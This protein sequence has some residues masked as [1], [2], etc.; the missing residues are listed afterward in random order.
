MAKK[1]RPRAARRELQRREEKLDRARERLADL[2]P[3]GAP[4]RAIDVESA[5]QVEVEAANRPCPRCGGP[6]RVDEHAAETVGAARLRVAR[7]SCA[8]CGASRQIW[9]RLGGSLPS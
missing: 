7:V 5:S 3:G 4:E 8:R 2:A 1:R 6:I 9:F